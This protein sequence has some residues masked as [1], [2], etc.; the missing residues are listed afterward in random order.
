METKLQYV[1]ASV[2]RVRSMPSLLGE[3]I[4]NIPK[5][6]EVSVI[7]STPYKMKIEDKYDS[8]SEVITPSGKVGFSYS[9][10]LSTN[11]A[12]NVETDFEPADGILILSNNSPTFWSNPGVQLG[13]LDGCNSDRPG[14]YLK[15]EGSKSVNKEKYFLVN[16]KINY[17]GFN[18]LESGGCIN[19]WVQDTEG[20]LVKNFYEWSLK[21]HGGSFDPKLVQILHED[22]ESL[23]DL[24]T[25]EV[26]DLGNSGKKDEALFEITY[27]AIDEDF[28]QKRKIH[29]LYAKNQQG[30]F[31]L[32]DNLGRESYSEDFDDDGIGEWI[33]K[34]SL[35]SGEQTT[36]YS[37]S[38][39]TFKPFLEIEDSEY[40]PC[41]IRINDSTDIGAYR[42]SMELPSPRCSVD[43]AKTIF[44]FSIE[45]KKARY[46]FSKGK[47]IALKK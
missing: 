36:Y 8:W 27:E 42:A 45:N 19:A 46:K 23:T 14:K 4:E 38:G 40:N 9:G 31:E 17:Y 28:N 18:S 6:T 1:D 34:T 26:N 20:D 2:L 15:V 10:F 47:L 3:V 32:M 43:I 44:T 37:R 24:S 25:L 41:G 21:Q 22:V 11:T 16:R 7:G 30:Y 35:R 13:Q 5:G 29:K 12:V 39:N 33:V